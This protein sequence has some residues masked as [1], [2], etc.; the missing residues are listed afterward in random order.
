MYVGVAVNITDLPIVLY[1][2][3]DFYK[4]IFHIKSLY[5]QWLY[6]PVCAS[7]PYYI[8]YSYLP[9]KEEMTEASLQTK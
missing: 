6:V 7:V 8:S 3:T 9:F 1:N 2:Y 5:C 4:K